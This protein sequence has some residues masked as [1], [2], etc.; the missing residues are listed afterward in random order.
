MCPLDRVGLYIV[1]MLTKL[2]RLLMPV[3][4]KVAP[5][6]LSLGA[7]GCGVGAAWTQGTFWGLIGT[8]GALLLAEWRMVEPA[9][10]QARR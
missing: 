2:A 5:A 3:A 8:A 6:T 7:L 4:N 10:E 1:P 9:A